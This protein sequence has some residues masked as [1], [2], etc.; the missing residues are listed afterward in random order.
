MAR[1]MNDPA[2]FLTGTGTGVGK[3]VVG[4]ALASLWAA[5][6]RGPRVLKPAESGCAAREGGLHPRDAWA[7]KVA[8]GDGRPLDEICPYRYGNPMAPA[9]A[10]EEEGGPPDIERIA[11]TITALRSRPG[12][13]LVEG[14]GGLLVPLGPGS[15]MIDI[16]ARCG[17]ALLIVAPL[18]LGA[19]NDTQLT[20][21]AARAEG[22]SVAGIVL[23]DRTGEDSPAA[24]RNPAAIGELCDARLLG[25]FPYLSGID[26]ELER[27]AAPE[28]QAAARLR[29]AARGIDFAAIG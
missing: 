10:A 6:G 19:L 27:G 16:A 4:C 22:L 14:A 28:S 1:R 13:L 2:I 24:R 25:V 11:E 29:E 26:A 5:A 15:R 21:R 12:P 9:H 17:L 18:G 8:A 7:L 3:T 20:V 23:N